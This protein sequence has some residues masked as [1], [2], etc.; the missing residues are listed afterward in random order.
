MVSPRQVLWVLAC[1]ATLEAAQVDSA[2]AVLFRYLRESDPSHPESVWMEVQLHLLLGSIYMSWGLGSRLTPEKVYSRV[3]NEFRIAVLLTQ[4][5]ESDLKLLQPRK[6]QT[7][8][9]PRRYSTRN[10]NMRE[11]GYIPPVSLPI[12]MRRL[13]AMAY[14]E[15]AQFLSR[16]THREH[17]A[18]SCEKDAIDCIPEFG[19]AHVTAATCCAYRLVTLPRRW[20]TSIGLDRRAR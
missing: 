18:L 15:Y 10:Y 4:M 11:L 19:E 2:M 20:S 1:H 16:Q 6:R 5:S 7:W 8:R 14:H 3:E 17:D 9:F 12:D 13:R